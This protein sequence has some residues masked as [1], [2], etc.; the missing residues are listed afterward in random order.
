MWGGADAKSR[1]CLNVTNPGDDRSVLQQAPPPTPPY[2]PPRPPAPNT[3]AQARTGVAVPR[4]GAQR[5]P[6]E[7]DSRRRAGLAVR[8]GKRGGC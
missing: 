1:P 5:G 2:Y 6:A 3:L 8:I 7:H 4:S